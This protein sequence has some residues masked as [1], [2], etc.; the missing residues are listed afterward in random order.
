MQEFEDILDLQN[1][2]S[3]NEAMTLE[4]FDALM[5][6]V[7]DEELGVESVESEEQEVTQSVKTTSDILSDSLSAVSSLEDEALEEQFNNLLPDLEE[8]KEEKKSPTLLQR[9]FA[10]I[11]PENLEEEIAAMKAADQK[12]EEDKKKKAKDKQKK[13]EEKQKQ[14]AEKKAAKAAA[15]DAKA[16]AKADAKAAAKAEKEKKREELEKAYVPEGKINKVGATIVTGLVTIIG[17][18]ILV[19]CR[20][21]PKQ[22][23][24][25]AGFFDAKIGRYAEAYQGLAGMKLSEEEEEVYAK[26][27]TVMYMDKQKKSYYN[28]MELGM[29]VEALDSLLKGL[30]SYDRYKERAIQYGVKE[31]YDMM[32]RELL[33]ELKKTYGLAE[34]AAKELINESDAVTYTKSLH[35]ICASLNGSNKKAAK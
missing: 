5:A 27:Q 35:Q 23:T 13:K 34:S 2:V 11:E 7:V 8:V 22:L 20:V 17:V 10:N 18:V 25:N 1:E 28:F 26:V 3:S 24:I 31:E 29:P 6:D 30:G 9:M 21:V 19:G 12:R 14:A 16:K 33:Q 4:E 15:K 32:R